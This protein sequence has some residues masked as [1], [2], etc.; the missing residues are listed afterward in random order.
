ME[1]EE[2]V[3]DKLEEKLGNLEHGGSEQR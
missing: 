2:A 3:K 1:S